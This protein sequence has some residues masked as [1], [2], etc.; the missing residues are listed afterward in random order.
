MPTTP[1]IV[2]SGS[3]WRG[4]RRSADALGLP[5]GYGAMWFGSTAG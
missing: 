2:R 1:R 3:G 5:A 4:W